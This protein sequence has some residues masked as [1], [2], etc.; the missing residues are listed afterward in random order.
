M[1]HFSETICIYGHNIIKKYDTI[2]TKIGE[3][4]NEDIITKIINYLFKY[5]YKKDLINL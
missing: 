4:E 3:I 1:N 5:I 2:N